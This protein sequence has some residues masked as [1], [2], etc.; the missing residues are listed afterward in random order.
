[1]QTGVLETVGRGFAEGGKIVLSGGALDTIEV[2]QNSV[3]DASGPRGGTVLIRGGSFVLDDSTISANTT[4][5]AVDPLVGVLGEGID[6]EVA[7]EVVI[8]NGSVLETNV[9]EEA[10]PGIG[11]G[12]IRVKADSVEVRGDFENF[13]PTLILSTVAPDSKGGSSG[14]ID[15][16]ANSV[17]IQDGSTIDTTTNSDGKGGDIEVTVEGGNLSL[18]NISF[19]SVGSTSDANAG[20][21]NVTVGKEVVKGNTLVFEGGDV[22]LSDFGGIFSTVQGSGLGGNVQLRAGNLEMSSGGNIGVEL[23]FVSTSDNPGG[24]LEITL[25]DNL[26]MSGGAFGRSFID[27]ISRGERPSGGMTITAMDIVVT[28]ASVIS[29]Q[30]QG[31]GL[32]GNLNIIADN[33]LVKDGGIITSSAST[34]PPPRLPVENPGNAGDINI[35]LNGDLVVTTGGRILADTS[36][37]GDGGSINVFATGLSVTEGGFLTAASSSTGNAGNVVVNVADLTSDTG[38]EIISSSTSP[39]ADAGDAG[40]IEINATNSIDLSATTVST[41][42]TQGQ[43]GDIDV[44]A[45]QNFQLSNNSTI[46]AESAGP[47]DSGAVTLT[48]TGGNFQSDNSTVSTSAQVGEGGDIDITAGQDVQLVSNTT[49]S[50]ESFGPGDAGDITATSGNDLQV[51]NSTISTQ[52]AQASGGNIKLT[53]PNTIQIINSNILSS[54]NGPEGSDGG[55]INID[56]LFIF[57]QNSRILARAFEGRGGNINLTATRAIFVDEFSIINAD[58]EFGQSGTISV[59][60]PIAVLA[61]VIAPLPKNF[62]RLANLFG[63]RCAAQKGGQFSSFTQGGPD[64]FPPAPGGF[65]PSPLMFSNPGAPLSSALPFSRAA[66]LASH[67]SP[68]RLGLDPAISSAHG[69]VDSELPTINLLPESGCAAA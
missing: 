64:G 7:G 46:S 65:L 30:A 49:I 24:S 57:I 51:I 36:N 37:D 4:G 50:A 1:M 12:G 29:T 47:G 9:T 10:S 53:A 67:L 54:V 26:T 42:A 20:N 15:I 5:L 11:S 21:I 55:N 60:S 44:N 69:Q 52:A 13:I 48:A 6:I 31:E 40:T 17:S 23:G 43:G 62:V 2:S 39:E 68:L 19:L 56:P 3:I 58:S 14:D 35:D 22:L 18:S 28:D 38:A 45:G 66:V 63:E 41:S 32:G 34:L 25:T 16:A 8:K 59:N 61:E 27:V 33:L